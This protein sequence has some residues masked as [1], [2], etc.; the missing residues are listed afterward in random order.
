MFKTG[1]K[2]LGQTIQGWKVVDRKTT[3]YETCQGTHATFI[4]KKKVG[5][6]IYTMTLSDR[7]M[8]QITKHS[9][10]I[11][12]TIKGKASDGCQKYLHRVEQNTIYV[13]KKF[14][15]LFKRI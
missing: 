13:D 4:L 15:N 8:T 10:S 14:S 2:Y 12:E 6:K 11:E 1:S 5:T 7:E 3:R 9:K